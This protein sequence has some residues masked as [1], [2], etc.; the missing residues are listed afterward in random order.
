MFAPRRFTFTKHRSIF[1]ESRLT[2]AGRR[3]NVSA[4]VKCTA[5]NEYANIA[6]RLH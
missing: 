6:P 5:A 1:A 3:C 2:F 4:T